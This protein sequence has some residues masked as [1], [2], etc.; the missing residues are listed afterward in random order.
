MSAIAILTGAV[1]FV[2]IY[3]KIIIATLVTSIILCILS[4]LFI[5][6]SLWKS[7]SIIYHA[8]KLRGSTNDVLNAL[9]TLLC[10]WIIGCDVIIIILV[11]VTL[12]T[13]LQLLLT[14]VKPNRGKL[15]AASIISFILSVIAIFMHAIGTNIQPI[16]EKIDKSGLSEAE[17]LTLLKIQGLCVDSAHFFTCY[18]YIFIASYIFYGIYKHFVLSPN[19]KLVSDTAN[20]AF[21]GSFGRKKNRNKKMNTQGTKK[22][23]KIRK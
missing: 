6:L 8:N 20:R 7:F 13:Y 16:I 22:S 1:K 2:E 10:G 23:K 9:G 19:A 14:E 15:Y 18:L 12:V 4:I 17:M 5:V 11:L 21:S 3:N